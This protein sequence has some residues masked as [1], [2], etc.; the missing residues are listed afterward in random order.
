MK[1]PPLIL[2]ISFLSSKISGIKSNG[3]YNPMEPPPP[4]LTGSFLSF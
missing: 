3:D 1:S 2:T 4:I